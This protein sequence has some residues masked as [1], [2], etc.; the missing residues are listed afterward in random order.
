MATSTAIVATATALAS[1]TAVAT[2]ETPEW[3]SYIIDGLFLLAFLYVYFFTKP[4]EAKPE[5]ELTDEEKPNE[6][7]KVLRTD[8]EADD[9]S[10]QVKDSDIKAEKDSETKE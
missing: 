7:E 6:L 10:G 1:G 3:F 8:P 9:A 5:D 4:V 2:G